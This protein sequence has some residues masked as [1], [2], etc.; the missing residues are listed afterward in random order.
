MFKLKEK[1]QQ[2]WKL[3][4]FGLKIFLITLLFTEMDNGMLRPSKIYS[5]ERRTLNKTKIIKLCNKQY[6]SGKLT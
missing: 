4:N 6:F 2:K 3:S 5:N 1:Y